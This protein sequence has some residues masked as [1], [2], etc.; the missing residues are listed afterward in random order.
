MRVVNRTQLRVRDGVPRHGVTNPTRTDAA[1]KET[2][3]YDLCIKH[4]LYYVTRMVVD[5]ATIW[6]MITRE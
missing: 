2:L 5:L 6:W 1:L 4:S 3:G